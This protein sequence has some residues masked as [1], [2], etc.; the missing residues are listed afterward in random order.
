MNL[1]QLKAADGRSAMMIR[2][3][4]V[5]LNLIDD[6]DGEEDDDGPARASA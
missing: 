6:D 2:Q 4:K 5:N 3:Y 1:L